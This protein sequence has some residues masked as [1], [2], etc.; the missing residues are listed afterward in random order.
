MSEAP[1]KH[2]NPASQEARAECYKHRDAYFACA[3]APTGDGAARDC[4]ALRVAFEGACLPSWVKHFEQRRGY[5]R[6]RDARIKVIEEQDKM[7]RSRK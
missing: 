6:D 5:E 1:K 2:A 4:S 3:E 7:A